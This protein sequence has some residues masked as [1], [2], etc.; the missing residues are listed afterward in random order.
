MADKSNTQR[1]KLSEENGTLQQWR[2]TC[3]FVET[4]GGCNLRRHFETKH[5][6]FNRKYD[7]ELREK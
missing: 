6:D 2:E 1:R 7:G 5:S 4:V 3:F